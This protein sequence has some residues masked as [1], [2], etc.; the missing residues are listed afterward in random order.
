[1]TPAS[2]YILKL[3][4]TG[5]TPK[6]ESGIGSLLRAFDQH[7]KG[8][9]EFRIINILDNPKLAEVDRILATPTLIK[10]EPPPVKRVIGDISNTDKV[11]AGLDIAK[12]RF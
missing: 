1:M 7:L 4:T 2:E 12:R 9:Y 6:L 10:E 5:T 11:L 3:Y 8:H